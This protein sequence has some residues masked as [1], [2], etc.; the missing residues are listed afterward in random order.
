[1]SDPK[2]TGDEDSTQKPQTIDPVIT[3]AKSS[4]SSDD[5]PPDDSDGAHSEGESDTETEKKFTPDKRLLNYAEDGNLE[6]VEKAL[7]DNANVDAKT[8]IGETALHLAARHGYYQLAELLIK[9]SAKIE[10][11]DDDGWVPLYGAA[12]EGK[13]DVVKLLLEW[14]A[15]PN[16]KRPDGWTPLLAALRHNFQEII[17]LLL[18]CDEINVSTVNDEGCSPLMMASEYSSV[19][20][21]R[22]LLEKNADINV[23]DQDG[24]APILT[25]LRYRNEDVITTLLAQDPDVHFQ[26][27]DEYTPLLMACRHSTAN[28][29]QQLID[30]KVDV[31]KTN[32]SNESELHVLAYNENR[33]DIGQITEKLLGY[34]ANVW[35]KAMDDQ[36]PLHYAGKFGCKEMIEPLLDNGQPIDVLDC[37]DWTPLHLACNNGFGDVV[38][39]LLEKGADRALKT[40]DTGRD[41]LTLAVRC[42]ADIFNDAEM[43]SE[44]KASELSAAE[45]AVKALAELANGTEKT[46]AFRQAECEGNFE[47]VAKAMG[48]SD[49]ETKESILIWTAAR[50]EKH[51]EILNRLDKPRHKLHIEANTP[52]KL[53]AYHGRYVVVWWLLRTAPPSS[54][55]TQDRREAKE[56]AEKMKLRNAKTPKPAKERDGDRG[57]NDGRNDGLRNQTDK[58]GSGTDD[59]YFLTLDMLRD[60]P[61]VIE[62]SDSHRLNE[63][64]KLDPSTKEEIEKYDATIV[65]FYNSNGRVDLLRRSRKMWNVIYKG[66]ST[67]KGKEKDGGADQIMQQARQT[68]GKISE[69]AAKEKTYLP[70]DL[71]MRW[72]HLPLNNVSGNCLDLYLGR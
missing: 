19:D 44:K 52:L 31:N 65:D 25:A 26:N 59:R 13:A 4:L 22:S 48:M 15:D 69:E 32:N 10:A 24:W 12:I 46:A 60:P 51:H 72:I 45:K 68:L 49:P 38:E 50:H 27:S 1:M 17:D 70:E 28:V 42:Y 14:D 16:A 33:T 2:P 61:P 29:V 34:G 18:D 37:D 20:V 3:P 64:L 67:E 57:G 9:R 55:A 58:A 30:R 21:V 23:R 66:A 53:A 6:G 41:A 39:L 36:M 54:K 7:D 71:R 62:A 8:N 40:G 5:R 56:I 47:D 63:K 11:R 43:D 35:A